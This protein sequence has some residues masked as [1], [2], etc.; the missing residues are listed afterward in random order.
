MANERW[1][2]Y[3]AGV[4]A[5]NLCNMLALINNSSYVVKIDRAGFIRTYYL[6]SGSVVQGMVISRFAGGFL[7]DTYTSIA[8][9]P[10]QVFDLMP[11][12][13]DGNNLSFPD[14]IKLKTGGY[15]TGASESVFRR[16]ILPSDEYSIMSSTVDEG[17]TNEF[18]TVLI[19]NGYK[20]SN[21]Q[22]ITIRPG[23]M[24]SIYQLE[25]AGTP[26]NVTDFWMEFTIER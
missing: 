3:A 11:L 25:S 20:D 15:P 7:A 4:R 2:V 18:M 26:A 9:Q 5:L 10:F 12:P 13:L 23:E 19:D 8:W 14:T 1:N 16:W 24:F 22:K 6:S 21:V 17:V